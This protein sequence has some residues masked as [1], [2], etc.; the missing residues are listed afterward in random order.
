MYLVKYIDSQQQIKAKTM[1]P[2][3]NQWRQL[4]GV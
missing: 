3:M 2:L 4:N 1:I